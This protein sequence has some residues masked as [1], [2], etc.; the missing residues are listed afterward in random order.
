MNALADRDLLPEPSKCEM[1]DEMTGDM[2]P[3]TN[4]QAAPIRRLPDH[5]VDRIAAGEVVERPANVVK[6]LVENSLDAGALRIE[7]ALSGAG[8]DS[9]LITD[10]GIGMTPADMRQAIARHATSKLPDENLLAISS[11]GFRG[12]ALPAIASVSRF[13]LASRPA[14]AATGWHLRIDGGDRVSDAPTAMPAGTRV[15]VEDL[16]GRVPARRKFLKSARSELSAITDMV[17]RLAMA[18]PQ[19]GFTLIHD[20]RI[21]L[22]VA[23]ETQKGVA[24]LAERTARLLPAGTDT[25]A[26]DFVRDDLTI[27]GLV[28]LPA[29]S[30]GVAD[31]QYL[32]VNGR[33]VRDR[34][35]TGALRGAYA[36]RLPRDRHAIAALYITLPLHEVDVNVHPAKTEVRFRDSARIRAGLIVAVRTALDAAGV[37][38]TAMAATALARSFAPEPVETPGNR[39]F[40]TPAPQA[41]NQLAWAEPG[42]AY[43]TPPAGK[44]AQRLAMPDN[45]AP[46]AKGNGFPLGVARGQIANT[47]IIAESDDGLII[48]D[49][50]AAHERLV[51][52][53]LRKTS[54]G[55]PA[56]MQHLL[57]P[58][59]VELDAQ[60]CDQLTQW[61]NILA[62]HGLEL[63]R[64]GDEA[65][66]VRAIPAALN[67]PDVHM[68]LRDLADDLATHDMPLALTE[69]LE[70]I[71]ATMACHGSVRAGRA[72]GIAEMNALLRQMEQVPA[73]GT[74]NHGRPTFI[75]LGSADLQKLF[76]RR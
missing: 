61:C 23:T 40:A 11:F 29:A 4:R 14:A 74:C 66:L 42:L 28:S 43:G 21:L 10:D 63:E 44:S 26:V 48:I 8:T 1:A 7:I 22:R 70:H 75:K 24:G 69:R 39:A 19:T 20:G 13:T 31:H 30:R 52:E 54:D 53:S 49:Q 73:S 38:P 25:V 57:M 65:M 17:R 60:A 36:D 9:M 27:G 3:F 37:R 68:L 50:H 56:A 34:M 71:A 32:F 46:E 16:F 59:V 5:L 18:H 51:L 33:P 67:S 6:E 64:F 35:L 76:G 62:A 55:E 41:P 47:Y 2:I 72:L 45:V 15:L 58:Q 12:E